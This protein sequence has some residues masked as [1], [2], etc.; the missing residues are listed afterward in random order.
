[1]LVIADV[2]QWLP[3]YELFFDDKTDYKHLRGGQY[4]KWCWSS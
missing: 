3:I 4:T 2:I 1:M